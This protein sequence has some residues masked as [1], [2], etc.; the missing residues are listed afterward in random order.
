MFLAIDFSNNLFR[1]V[2]EFALYFYVMMILV[3]RNY[4]KRNFFTVPKTIWLFYLVLYFLVALLF[5]ILYSNIPFISSY[6]FS[7]VVGFFALETILIRYI[8]F[9]NMDRYDFL[10]FR[11]VTIGVPLLVLGT[12]SVF[13]YIYMGLTLG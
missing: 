7:V 13:Y 2:L 8:Y 10:L 9:R 5:T 3:G 11:M 12:A 1:Y 4:L 6:F